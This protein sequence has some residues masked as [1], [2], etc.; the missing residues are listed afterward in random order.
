MAAG[1]SIYP[2]FFCPHA[3]TPKALNARQNDS[4]PREWDEATNR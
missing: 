4:L 2:E 1:K 3:V